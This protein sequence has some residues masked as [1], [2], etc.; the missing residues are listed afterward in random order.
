MGKNAK[1]KKIR[2]S[3]KAG[4]KS[5]KRYEQTQFV[6]Q[7]EK[8][9]YQLKIDPKLQP[10]TNRGNISPEIPQDRIEPQL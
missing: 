10:K 3:S 6:Q 1:L 9:G 4:N 8:M 7:F 5:A 2:S